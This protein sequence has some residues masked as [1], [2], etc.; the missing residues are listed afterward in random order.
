M[1]NE[2]KLEICYQCP[3]YSDDGTGE[4]FEGSSNSARCALL[5]NMLIRGSILGDCPDGRW[6]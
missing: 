1:T 3:H 6:Q 5:D 2:Q 4:E